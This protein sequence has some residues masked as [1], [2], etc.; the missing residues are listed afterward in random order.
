MTEL[1]ALHFIKHQKGIV[2]DIYYDCKKSG[3]KWVREDMPMESPTHSTQR[4]NSQMALGYF[5][6]YLSLVKS[7][8]CCFFCD[9]HIYL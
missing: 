4:R 8:K 6:T 1:G 5:Q 2:P 3:G 7:K 9:S